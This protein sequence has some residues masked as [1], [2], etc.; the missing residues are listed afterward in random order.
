MQ[1]SKPSCTIGIPIS[2]IHMDLSRRRKVEEK[3]RKRNV[4]RLD[5]GHTPHAKQKKS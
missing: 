2:T 5:S 1:A 3:Q 4:V